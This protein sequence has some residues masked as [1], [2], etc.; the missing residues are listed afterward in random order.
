MEI[1]ASSSRSGKKRKPKAKLSDIERSFRKTKRQKGGKH[2]RVQV[3]QEVKELLDLLNIPLE[4]IDLSTHPIDALGSSLLPGD[5]DGLEGSTR[6][7]KVKG[8]GSCLF[9]AVP[10]L[11]CGEWDRFTTQLRKLACDYVEENVDYIVQHL[12]LKSA[13]KEMR[14]PQDCVCPIIVNGDTEGVG[15][16]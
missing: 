9:N 2:F 14:R 11:L 10:L 6:T 8:D 12:A 1:E 16:S 13:A 15:Q 7:L 5:V 4:A 3:A